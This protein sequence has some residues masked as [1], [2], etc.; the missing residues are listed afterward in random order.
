M[1]C[2]IDGVGIQAHYDI[3]SFDAEML[4]NL[5]IDIHELGLDVQITEVDFSVYDYNADT[6]LYYTEFTPEMEELQAHCFA[7]V[8]EIAR[9][10]KDKVSCVTQWGVADDSS[11][12][13][14]MPVPN[15]NDWPYLFDA[16]H[17]P[18]LAYEM[19]MDF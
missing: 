13:F 3:T 5:I 14:N 2:E 7:K 10:H 12:L 16:D 1:G 9:K 19:V 11:Y 6:S 8:F 17:Q 15:R 4:E 18:K